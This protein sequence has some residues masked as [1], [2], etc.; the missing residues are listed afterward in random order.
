M[1]AA[2]GALKAPQPHPG[3]GL[4]VDQLQSVSML[5]RFIECE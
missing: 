5:L 2:P 1:V 3:S 4:R